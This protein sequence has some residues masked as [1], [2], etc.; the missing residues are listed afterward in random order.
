MPAGERMFV[1]FA[2]DKAPLGGARSG[3]VHEAE[4][5]VSV[6]GARG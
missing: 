5:F 3:E 6:L 1:D 2:G 4:V